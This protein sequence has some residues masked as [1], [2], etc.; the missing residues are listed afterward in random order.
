MFM[1]NYFTLSV[2]LPKAQHHG[3]IS[4]P[5]MSIRCVG[6]LIYR[7]PEGRNVTPFNISFTT[8]MTSLLPDPPL[9]IQNPL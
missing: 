1:R 5:T 6:L 9:P 7:L 8:L 2:P 3:S 4:S